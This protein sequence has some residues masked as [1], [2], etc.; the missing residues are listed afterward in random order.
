MFQLDAYLDGLQQCK[1]E[2]ALLTRFGDTLKNNG[3]AGY[4]FFYSRLD[5]HG[6]AN[7]ALGGYEKSTLPIDLMETYRREG[8]ISDDPLLALGSRPAMPYSTASVF[9]EVVPKSAPEKMWHAM[10]DHQIEHEINIPL[11]G[12]ARAR[13]ISVHM[14][15]R[16][17]DA[18]DHFAA[19]LP[20]AH[21]IATI[22]YGVFESRVLSD[23]AVLR[24]PYNPL[25]P[26]ERDCLTWAAKG[27]TNIAIGEQLGIGSRTVKFHIV[28]AM[29]KLGADSRSEAI[30]LAISRHHIQL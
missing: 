5:T 21:T 23:S 24:E 10:L 12:A 27:K 8:W 18:N 29:R 13:Q 3:F 9:S 28:N 1:G 26:R 2:E 17:Q 30:A 14:R 16:G 15:G 25:T 22:F 11:P 7:P 4:D 6:R 20:I 19:S